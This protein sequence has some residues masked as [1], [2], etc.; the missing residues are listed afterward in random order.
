VS[1]RFDATE[2]P[3]PKKG[4]DPLELGSDWWHNAC[5]NF[6]GD[7][8]W[9]AYAEGYRLAG[10]YLVKRVEETRSDQDS[11]VYPILFNYRQ[12]LELALKGIVRDARRLFD[13]DGGAPLG[14]DLRKLWE[15]ASPL[16]ARVQV[17]GQ[18]DRDIARDCLSRFADLDKTSQVFRYPVDTHGNVSLPADL[19]HINLRQVRDV[20]ERLSGFFDAVD[21]Q[22]SANLEYK[23]N[24]EADSRGDSGDPL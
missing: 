9:G 5:L 15:I 6:W 20:V 21:A 10:D 14:H 18:D 13:I 4:D 8:P 3:W 24:A 16:L 2:H 22:I 23:W 1:T 19:F 17:R 11:L 7:S 12:Y